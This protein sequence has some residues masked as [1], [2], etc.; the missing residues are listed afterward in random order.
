MEILKSMFDK[1]FGKNAGLELIASRLRAGAPHVTAQG[2]NGESIFWFTGSGAFLGGYGKNRRYDVKV[3]M[4]FLVDGACPRKISDLARVDEDK[5]LTE[6]L[7]NYGYGY[8][9]R[10]DVDLPEHDTVAVLQKLKQVAARL[11]PGQMYHFDRLS[12]TQ[13]LFKEDG[14]QL[15]T[16]SKRAIIVP[17]LFI[18]TQYLFTPTDINEPFNKEYVVVFDDAKIQRQH[19]RDDDIKRWFKIEDV[20]SVENPHTFKFTHRKTGGAATRY[21]RLDIVLDSKGLAGR[22]F[23]LRE[24]V[25]AALKELTKDYP[26]ATYELELDT[27]TIMLKYDDNVLTTARAYHERQ[28]KYPLMVD[29]YP[30]LIWEDLVVVGASNAHGVQATYKI[31]SKDD[32]DAPQEKEPSRPAPSKETRY[33]RR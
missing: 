13:D 30:K 20:K 4:I 6:A 26:A 29:T 23:Y 10:L 19:R 25:L 14:I 11:K 2:R 24:I 18:G 9:Q 31:K 16:R 3:R 5:W 27:S 12:I 1:W 7:A 33:Q 32:S 8:I 17:D 15:F 28:L 21:Y 22:P